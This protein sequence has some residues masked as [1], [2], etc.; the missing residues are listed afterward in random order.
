MMGL[1]NSLKAWL[2]T[3]AA[4]LSESAKQMEERLD[5]DLSKR[6]RQ[7]TET[8]D[9][10]MKRLQSEIEDGES[11]FEAISDKIGHASAKADAV[12][13]LADSDDEIDPNNEA[14]D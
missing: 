14:E 6:E 10:A 12:A 3:E 7:L 8:P 9:E 5:A 2:R 1:L 11:S 13:D 4:E